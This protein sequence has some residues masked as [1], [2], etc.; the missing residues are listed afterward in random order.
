MAPLL[1]AYAAVSLVVAAALLPPALS[2]LPLLILALLVYIRVR[3]PRRAIGLA[4]HVY[5]FLVLPLLYEQMLRPA[6]S[7]LLSLPLLGLVDADL[8][9]FSSLQ[10]ARHWRFRWRP[11]RTLLALATIALASVLLSWPLGRVST[12]LSGAF[13]GGYLLFLVIR[14]FRAMP[15]LPIEAS[16]AQYRVVAGSRRSFVVPLRSRFAF[17]GWLE[18]TTPYGW[19]RLAPARLSLAEGQGELHVSLTPPWPGRRRSA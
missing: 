3:P 19:V 9:G 8:R 11:S 7:P 2:P 6:L 15:P 5:I 17:G 12:L 14:V 4:L 1:T 16:V 18:L 13:L 10:A